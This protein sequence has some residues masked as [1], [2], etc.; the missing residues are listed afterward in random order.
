MEV[1]RLLSYLETCGV[2]VCDDLPDFV[3]GVA[4]AV[5]TGSGSQVLQGHGVAIRWETIIHIEV[6][7]NVHDRL[8]EVCES[9]TDTLSVWAVEQV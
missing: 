2:G 4:H 8:R 5:D 1:D 3:T 6:G 9:L 7:S